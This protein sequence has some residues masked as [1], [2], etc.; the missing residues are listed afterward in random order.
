[1][2]L[3]YIYIYIFTY[4]SQ[5]TFT[6]LKKKNNLIYVTLKYREYI[7]YPHISVFVVTFFLSSTCGELQGDVAHQPEH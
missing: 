6:H 3:L 7:N 5:D 4:T 1:M 2:L